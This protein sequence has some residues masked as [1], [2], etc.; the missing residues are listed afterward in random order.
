M[1]QGHGLTTDKKNL[2]SKGLNS[3]GVLKGTEINYRMKYHFKEYI[4]CV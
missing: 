2:N 1:G 3:S 4:L